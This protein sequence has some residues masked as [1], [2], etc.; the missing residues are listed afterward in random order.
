MF[1]CSEKNL[2]PAAGGYYFTASFQDKL[3]MFIPTQC[4]NK[5]GS[6]VA[7][8]EFGRFTPRRLVS[9]EILHSASGASV[10]DDAIL[11]N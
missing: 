11:D 10:G 4:K 2:P 7:G 6:R 9:E 1:V 5:S 8:F 3:Q